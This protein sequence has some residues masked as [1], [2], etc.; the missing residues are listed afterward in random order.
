MKISL[1]PTGILTV[2]PSSTP[3]TTVKTTCIR[4]NS[5]NPQA[6]PAIFYKLYRN[7][8]YIFEVRDVWPEVPI[9]LGFLNN[10]I[11]KYLAL[12]LEKISYKYSDS[13]IA[14]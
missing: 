12:F 2:W 5:Q 11:L 3:A 10:P 7:K 14:N 9:A 6:I 1:F 8:P 13:I 4:V